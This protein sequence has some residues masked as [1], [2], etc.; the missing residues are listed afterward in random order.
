MGDFRKCARARARPVVNSGARGLG[1]RERKGQAGA[2]GQL[3]VRNR[4]HL[5]FWSQT[6][7]LGLLL[8]NLILAVPRGPGTRRCH[9]AA[10]G[11]GLWERKG[12]AGPWGNP[13]SETSQT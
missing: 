12:L 8:G 9:S 4:T 7:C 3:Q 1:L 6:L 10:R 5:A 2:L 13:K 11:L